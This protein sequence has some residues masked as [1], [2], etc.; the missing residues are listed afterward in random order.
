MWQSVTSSYLLN[1]TSFFLRAYLSAK[2]SVCILSGLFSLLLFYLSL[3]QRHQT[4]INLNNFVSNSLCF[5][6]FGSS[7]VRTFYHAFSVCFRAACFLA[8]KKLVT[9]QESIYK[10]FTGF[11]FEENQ[12]HCSEN[13]AAKCRDG[14]PEL[15]PSKCVQTIDRKSLHVVRHRCFM[16]E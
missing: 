1:T 8:D 9:G 3:S 14:G 11:N 2:F 4:P 12:R 16:V 10:C 15:R 13:A 5:S 6:A 7:S